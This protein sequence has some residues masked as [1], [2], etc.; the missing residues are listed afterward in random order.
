MTDDV[1]DWRRNLEPHQQEPADDLVG[2]VRAG[3]Q[4]M[5]A[6]VKWGRLTFTID[7]DWHHWVCALAVSKSGG[8]SLVFH[9]GSLLDDQAG[10]LEG[11]GAYARRV[12]YEQV[13]THRDAVTAM[14]QEA[15]Q[16]QNES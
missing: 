8:L 14:L 13:T 12:S 15:V 9:K 10:L 5:T 7:D 11:T 4:R 2:L 1:V 3:D 16:R 6:A